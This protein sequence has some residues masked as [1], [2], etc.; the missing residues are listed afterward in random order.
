[1]T[2][3]VNQMVEKWKLAAA[4]RIF[5]KVRCSINHDTVN[6]KSC[7]LLQPIMLIVV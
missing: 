6:V 4:V 1:M 2:N 5:C 3:V 7:K